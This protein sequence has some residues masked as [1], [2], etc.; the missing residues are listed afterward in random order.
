MRNI[1]IFTQKVWTFS[2]NV[3]LHFLWKSLFKFWVDIFSLQKRT[4][5]KAIKIKI[6]TKYI[7]KQNKK[8]L[9]VYSVYLTCFSISLIYFRN[10]KSQYPTDSIHFQRHLRI[11][12][13]Y[14]VFVYLPVISIW[15]LFLRARKYYNGRRSVWQPLEINTSHSK[16]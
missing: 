1:V 2:A 11:S 5:I 9:F 16:Y 10:V 13:L 7:V 14:L 12:L 3:Y 8:P 15:P 4:K 6:H